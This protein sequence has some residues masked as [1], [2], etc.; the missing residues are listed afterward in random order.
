MQYGKIMQSVI[1]LDPLYGCLQTSI[2]SHIFHQ[3]ISFSGE[4]VWHGNATSE[5]ITTTTMTE[6]RK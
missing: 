2:L 4:I 6:A 3:I 1:V 5:L